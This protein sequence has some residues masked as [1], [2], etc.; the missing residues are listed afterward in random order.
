MDFER[1]A[2]FWQKQADDPDWKEILTLRNA[3]DKLIQFGQ[4]VGVGREEMVSLLDSGMTVR[5]LLYYLVSQSLPV[6]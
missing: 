2:D 5:G 1:T 3:V 6:N 4:Q